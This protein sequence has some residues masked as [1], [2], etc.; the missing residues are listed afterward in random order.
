MEEQETTTAERVLPQP[1]TK[2]S[3]SQ[4]SEVC[5]HIYTYIH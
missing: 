2:L 5:L 1:K 3:K 4:V